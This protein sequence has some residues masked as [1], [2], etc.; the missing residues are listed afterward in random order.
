MSEEITIKKGD[1]LI[2]VANT[3]GFRL[4]ETIWNDPANESLRQK[5]PDP[6]VLYEG[7]RIVVPEKTL[8]I[9]SAASSSAHRFRAKSPRCFIRIRLKDQWDKPFKDQ[10]YEFTSG[11]REW[12]G[13]TDANGIISLAVPPETTEGLLK[14]WPDPADDGAFVT[15]AVK[16]GYLD[17]VTET[18]G[19]QGRLNNLGFSC[20]NENGRM[21]E[22]TKLALHF[23]QLYGG[24]HDPK[25]ELDDLT[26]QMLWER[27]GNI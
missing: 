14:F 20:G 7:D 12:A 10:K 25:G 16:I 11:G 15:C 2:R 27:H 21:G 24:H 19:I 1:T 4:W 5:R 22:K 18:T 13:Q 17:P 9:L 6:Q 23:F 3:H 26:R 8:K